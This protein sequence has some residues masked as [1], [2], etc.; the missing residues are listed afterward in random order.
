MSIKII[1]IG[2]RQICVAGIGK[3]FY[4]D[5]FPV[6]MSRDILKEKGIEL[7]WLH[8]TDELYKNGWTH[9]RCLTTLRNEIDDDDVFIKVKSFIEVAGNHPTKLYIDN[10]YEDQ[11]EMLFNYLFGCSTKEVISNENTYPKYWLSN[12]L[13]KSKP[14]G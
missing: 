2:E 10:G 14:N 6:S 9:K 3:L 5:G 11:R 13:D 1:T 7:S 12:L 8:V 4:Q